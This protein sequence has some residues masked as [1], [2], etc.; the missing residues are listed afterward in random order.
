MR[1]RFS[2]RRFNLS[3]VTDAKELLRR[4]HLLFKG[5]LR[6]IDLAPEDLSTLSTL[7]IAGEMGGRHHT[8][9]LSGNRKT[10]KLLL[11]KYGIENEV[12]SVQFG[13]GENL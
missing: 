8:I 12:I 6:G 1:V 4:W 7:F 11:D 3:F 9:R 2:Q 5:K 10:L 13:N